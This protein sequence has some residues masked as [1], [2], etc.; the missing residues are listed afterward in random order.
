VTDKFGDPLERLVASVVASARYRH[1]CPDVIRR[2]GES[3]IGKRRTW[4]DAEKETRSRLHQIGGAFLD[5]RPPYARWIE[6][7]RTAP[8]ASALHSELRGMMLG[9][10]STCERLPI[11]NTY[12]A[13]TLASIRPI[14]SVIDI[15]CGFNPLSVPWMGLEESAWYEAYDLYAD[16]AEFLGAALR[17]SHFLPSCNV[18][19]ETRDL[20]TGPP[21]GEADLALILK[22]LPL[23]E[24]SNTIRT[25]EWLRKL[26]TRYAL[27]SFPTRT[28]GGR[29][30]GMAASYELR[31][32]EILQEAKW[33]A[34][35]F[36]F[37][38]EICFLVEIGVNGEAGK[39]K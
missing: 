32:R 36:V 7:L 34:E 18:R 33:T 9:H 24:Q 37:G 26:R 14:R 5:S 8:N 2:I 35:R 1:V 25:L 11:L 29:N 4:K 15:A 6:A 39:N 28:L 27:V 38:N 30:V 17:A 12:Y 31:F 13:Q 19:T 10:A 23:L 16:M 21:E 22:F 20:V 3:E